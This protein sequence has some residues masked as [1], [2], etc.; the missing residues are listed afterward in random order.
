MVIVEILRDDAQ[1]ST[2]EVGEI[3]VTNLTNRAM[4]FIRYNLKDEGLLIPDECS[5]GSHFP[6]MKIL[7]GRKSDVIQLSDG[8]IVSALAVYCRLGPVPGIKQF[9]LVQEKLDRF[10]VKLIK[11]TRFENKT[12][13]EI[14]RILRQSLGNAEVDVL[15]V[16]DI[17]KQGAGKLVPFISN[18]H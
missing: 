1:V 13:D 15:F 6:M 18:V 16:D 2:G 12:T 8:R 3:T 10:T 11:E 4:P 7:Q 17:P 9:Q 14:K 5:C